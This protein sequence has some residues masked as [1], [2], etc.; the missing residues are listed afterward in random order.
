MD[1][2]AI[3]AGLMGGQ[4]GL[5]FDDR[6][7]PAGVSQENLSRRCRANDSA[8]DHNNVILFGARLTADKILNTMIIDEFQE[9]VFFLNIPLTCA[10]RAGILA[11]EPAPPMSF[12]QNAKCYHFAVACSS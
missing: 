10:N 1:D 9:N 3:V 5:L 7:L 8:A 12:S 2:A 11:L 4:D 6:N